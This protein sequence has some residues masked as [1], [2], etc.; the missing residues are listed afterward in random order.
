MIYNDITNKNGAIQKCEDWL[1]GGDY[2]AISGNS[3]QLLKF[4]N[5][6]N[7]GLD[8][9]ISLIYQADARWQNDDP[10]YTDIPESTTNLSDGV[11][12]YGLE[13][14][15]LIIDGFEVLLADGTWRRLKPIDYADI[16]E[17]NIA[18]NE[19]KKTPGIPEEYDLLGTQVSLFP[20]PSVNTVTLING[21]K[22]VYRRE[23]SYFLSGD[24]TKEMGIPRTFHD[25]P[26]LFACLEYASMNSMEQKMVDISNELNRRKLELTKH[27]SLRNR[28]EKR[29][30]AVKQESNK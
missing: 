12:S 29:R 19:Y 8:K 20:S 5:L 2:G 24:T 21:L 18:L 1:Y 13:K 28:D 27:F 6:I 15:Q 17:K 9:T 11:K 4:T 7:S 16:K 3:I 25:V 22:I 30:L 10:N 23:S 14:S 26:C